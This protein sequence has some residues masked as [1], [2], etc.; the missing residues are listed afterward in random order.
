MK[1]YIAVES[2]LL[3]RVVNPIED[4]MPAL[5]IGG[6]TGFVSNNG[7]KECKQTAGPLSAEHILLTLGG[8]APW[9]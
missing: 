9:W 6:H 2:Y 8:A 3:A 7:N 5:G 4:A 1:R